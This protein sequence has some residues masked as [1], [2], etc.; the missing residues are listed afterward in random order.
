LL[1]VEIVGHY[2]TRAIS[3][4]VMAGPDPAIHHASVC[5]QKSSTR[6]ARLMDERVEPAH[7]GVRG[8]DK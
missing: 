3:L 4:A 5:E 8:L 1:K 7:D 6:E 2:I